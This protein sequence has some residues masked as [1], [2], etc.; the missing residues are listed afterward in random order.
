MSRIAPNAAVVIVTLASD[1]PLLEECLY[2]LHQQTTKPS[3]III[4]AD[5]TSKKQQRLLEQLCEKYNAILDWSYTKRGMANARN[6]GLKQA[7]KQIVAFID[8]D[9]IA[10]KDWIE[11][12]IKC[13]RTTGAAAIGGQVMSRTKNSPLIGEYL[14]KRSPP[15]TQSAAIHSLIGCNMSLVYDAVKE[16]GFFNP[17]IEYGLDETELAARLVRHGYKI[18]FCP[19]AIVKHDFAKGWKDLLWKTFK[20]GEKSAKLK[21][22]GG[23]RAPTP[24]KI[25]FLFTILR[26]TRRIQFF[27]QLILLYVIRRIGAIV[28]KLNA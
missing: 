24:I 10:E 6:I 17:E 18:G 21:I 5:G 15:D 3:L 26:E 12:L 13:H 25:R 16:I 9:A 8:D 28:G 2:A 27:F 4:I 23:L 1:L 11:Q 19:N 7:K 14:N 22:R 20:Q